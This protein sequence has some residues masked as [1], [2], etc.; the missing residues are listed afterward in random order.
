M[1]LWD[2]NG[3]THLDS[4]QS[5][6][7]ELGLIEF[8]RTAAVEVWRIN[9]ERYEPDEAYDDTFTLSILSSRNLSNRVLAEAPNREHLQASGVFVDKVFGSTLI[10]TPRA[11][12]RLVKAPHRSGR[13]PNFESDFDWADS[14]GRH[15]AAMRNFDTY[16]PPPR[17]PQVEPLFELELPN[18]AESVAQCREVFLVWGA[19][20]KDGLT[21]GWLGLPTT[22][23]R[24]WIA[25][26]PVWW[27]E[28][29]I[30]NSSTTS[31]EPGSD[32][33]STFGDRPAPVPSIAL[34]P[35]RQ[36]GN[37]TL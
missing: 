17:D 7:A 10:H 20:L 18:A 28:P 5:S 24:R 12:V 22:D 9:R 33:G 21:A 31:T 36:E 16:A 3:Q 37:S 27:D 35:Q 4:L 25:V 8:V 26:T 6:L 14:E 1:T 34:K 2:P 15:A 13:R 32:D 11:D 23:A 29:Q 30:R 19:D